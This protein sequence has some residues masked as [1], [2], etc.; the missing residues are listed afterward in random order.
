M[1]GRVATSRVDDLYRQLRSNILSGRHLPGSRLN[2]VDLCEVYGISSGVLREALPRLAGEGLITFE[3]QRGYRVTEVSVDDLRQLTEARVLVETKTLRQS[4]ECGDVEF[5]ANVVAAHHTLARCEPL[6]VTGSVRE[7]WLDAHSRFH[8]ALLAGSPNLR[9]QIIANSLR[10]STEVYRCWA[11]RFGD[12]PDRDVAGEHR[13]ILQAVV[14]RDADLA[15]AELT[16]HLERTT[17]V[18]IRAQVTL[19]HAGEGS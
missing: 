7:E 1:A 15:V 18:L 17:R 2:S 14:D 19:A 3:P 12:E 6:S 16:A 5:E 10:D 9:L 13:R 11:G 8:Q 4:I